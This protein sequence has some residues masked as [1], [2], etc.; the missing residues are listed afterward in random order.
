MLPPTPEPALEHSFTLLYQL[1]ANNLTA[2]EIVARLAK[3]CNDATLGLGKP[4]HVALD[5]TREADNFA[6][7]YLSAQADVLLAIPDAVRVD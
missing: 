2:D 7:A 1:P 6:D 4:N 5:F 3:H